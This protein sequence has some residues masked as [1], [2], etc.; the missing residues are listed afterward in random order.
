MS[1]ALERFKASAFLVI[2][3]G[4]L[5]FNYPFMQLRIPP[6]GFG[7][8]LGELLI[9]VVLLTI[10]LPRVLLRMNATVFLFP[11]LVWWSWGLGRFVFD[12]TNQGF[13]A[14]RDSTQLIESLFLIVGFALAGQ[15]RTV[16]RLVRWLRPIIIISC[17]YGLLFI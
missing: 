8:P 13:W 2:L 14:L 4:Y 3:A 5:L 10:D 17:L 15:P 6:V 1:K 12:T 16:A 11:F 9:A 7:F